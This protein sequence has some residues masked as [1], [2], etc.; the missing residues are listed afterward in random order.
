MLTHLSALDPPPLLAQTGMDWLDSF[1]G[2]I[3]ENLGDSLLNIV[4]AIAI[5]VIGWI[6]A[7]VIKSLSLRVLKKTDIDNKL[8][9]WLSGNKQQDL[10]IEQW[11]SEFF[12]W[13]II[14][15]TVIALLQTFQLTAVYEPLQGFINKVTAFFPQIFGAAVWLGVAWIVA[16]IVRAIATKGLT[17]LKI[18]EKLDQQVHGDGDGP[19]EASQSTSLNDTIGNAAYWFIFLL[20]LP[21]I[22][23]T[24]GLN[25]TLAPLQGL[26]N[27]VIL[28]LPNILAA[29]LIGAV[30]WLIAQ[31]VRR[32]VTNLLKASGADNLGKKFG[33]SGDQGLSW[34]L[35]TLAYVLI[36]IPV[37]IS[38]LEVLQI[39]AISGPAIAMLQDT[40]EILPKLLGAAIILTLAYVIGQYVS[41]LVTQILE[42]LGFNNVYRWLGFEIEG[43][44]TA[45]T[46]GETP[47]P[48]GG[49]SPS[50]IL[51]I[52][53]LVAVMLVAALTAVD[54][55]EIE[56]LT[57]VVA[58]ILEV[59]GRIL[60][61]LVIFAVGLY[62]SNLAY[63]LITSSGSKQSK[64]LGQTARIVILTLIA[65]MALEQLSIAP[66]IV[67]LAFGLLTGG[68]AV[69]I[70]LA[71]GL[72]GRDVA[73]DLLR[74]WLNNFKQD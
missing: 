6:S 74:S 39:A 11:I 1:L 10:P 13:L 54:I 40:L 21:P 29:V 45:P 5:L 73:A 51:G 14:L 55:L 31:V 37:S 38:A 17:Q 34:L 52:V 23:E 4:W 71:F 30:G 2:A 64:I 22:L 66:N 33:L 72:G 32:L 62:L 43:A 70:A 65:A 49:R 24:L 48:S 67:N 50:E 8:A 12:Y 26:I 60:V 25:S 57:T 7:T 61:A 18:A 59:A 69:A 20:F 9:A 15:F 36:L 16:T 58:I 56:A 68:V 3:G 44:V 53:V 19:T 42:G 41:E 27:K 35:G 28:I 63:G 46:D 47:A